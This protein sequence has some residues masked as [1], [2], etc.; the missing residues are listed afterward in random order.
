MTKMT[1]DELIKWARKRTQYI[2][3][4]SLYPHNKGVADNEDVEV[5]PFSDFAEIINRISI[6]FI[7]IVEEEE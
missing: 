7:E 1:R 5:I 2:N 3:N 4:E 6:G